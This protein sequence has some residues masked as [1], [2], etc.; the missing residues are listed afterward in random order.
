MRVF[1]SWAGVA[2]KALATVVQEW[3]PN[4]IQRVE[5]WYSPEIEKGSRWLDELTDGLRT[6]QAGIFCLTRESLSSVWMGFE[7]GAIAQV[8][9]AKVC[10]ILMGLKPSDVQYPLAQFQHTTLT[11]EDVFIL[12]STMN[13]QLGRIDG[14]RA[15][16][17]SQLGNAFNTW[18]PQLEGKIAKIAARGSTVDSPVRSEREL[19]EEIMGIVRT[20]P[21]GRRW[22]GSYSH[23]LYLPPDHFQNIATITSALLEVPGV[24]AVGP[25]YP[26]PSGSLSIPIRSEGIPT[27][28]SE[29][30]DVLNRFGLFWGS[31]SPM[32][33]AGMGLP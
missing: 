11:K 30:R 33:G 2:S 12:V 15:L 13:S 18:W 9:S 25:L 3:L 23:L 4:V 10:T 19:L 27:L 24:V 14:E 20:L 1:I 29:F 5:P 6:S 31:I 8:H 16:T 21:D 7:A 26:E 32:T 22:R 28:A 17:E